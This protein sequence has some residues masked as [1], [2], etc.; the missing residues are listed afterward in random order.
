MADRA[1]LVHAET[2]TGARLNAL[3]TTGQ[4]D[5]DCSVDEYGNWTGQMDGDPAEAI[6]AA[7]VGANRRL[8]RVADT[9]MD[10][11][12]R[13]CAGWNLLD[14]ADIVPPRLSGSCVDESC[15]EQCHP[16]YLAALRAW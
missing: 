15:D 11:V 6:S 10:R 13:V 4:S 3:P 12:D 7:M 2:G 14:V 8:D 9:R 5:L 16:R 1:W